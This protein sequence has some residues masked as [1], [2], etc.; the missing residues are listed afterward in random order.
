M[1]SDDA[2][3]DELGDERRIAAAMLDVVERGGADLQSLFVFLV[4]LRDAGV[5]I[6][7]VIIKARGVGDPADVVEIL[8]LP[9]P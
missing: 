9:V 5:E 4:P 2:I 3:G 8:M 1:A 7:A 6:P